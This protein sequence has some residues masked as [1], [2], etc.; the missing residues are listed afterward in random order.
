[1][2]INAN[3]CANQYDGDYVIFGQV[4]EGLDVVEQIANDKLAD[5]SQERQGS[6]LPQ[7]NITIESLTLE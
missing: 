6:G 5:E 1:M 7:E 2:F 3:D 4:I